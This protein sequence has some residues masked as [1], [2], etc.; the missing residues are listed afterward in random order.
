[1]KPLIIEEEAERELAGSVA[2]YE[3]RQS[4]LGLEFEQAT[5]EALKKIA[6]T[7]DRWPVSKQGNQTLSDGAFS[8]HYSLPGHAR[9]NLDCCLCGHQPKNQITGRQGSRGQDS[10]R[11]VACIRMLRSQPR[12]LSGLPLQKVPDGRFCLLYRQSLP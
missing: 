4:G 3:Q 2:F 10:G 11:R 12:R 1:V 8:T 9:Q 5:R 7:P 6:S